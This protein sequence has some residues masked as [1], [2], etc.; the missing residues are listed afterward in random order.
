MNKTSPFVISLLFASTSAIKNTYRPTAGSVPWGSAAARPTWDTPDHPVNYFV[1]NLGVD[2]NILTTQN[3]L[4]IAESE[5]KT[6]LNA[7]FAQSGN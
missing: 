5:S 3:S 2:H 1:P 7:K 6:Q 4:R